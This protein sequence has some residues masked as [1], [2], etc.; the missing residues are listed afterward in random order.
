MHLH[1]NAKGTLL[2]RFRE[3]KACPNCSTATAIREYEATM[4]GTYI[5][6]NFQRIEDLALMVTDPDNHLQ[7]ICKKCLRGRPKEL[8]DGT[9]PLYWVTCTSHGKNV[10]PAQDL[11]VLCNPKD[12]RIKSTEKLVMSDV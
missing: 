8:K 9:V 2:P 11:C 12:P 3:P 6:K 1:L 10:S 5:T 4:N 7:W